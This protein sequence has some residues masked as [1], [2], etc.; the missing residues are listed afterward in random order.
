MYSGGQERGL[1]ERVVSP[2]RKKCL[3]L[4]YLEVVAE[5]PS[6][7]VF[8]CSRQLMLSVESCAKAPYFSA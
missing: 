3:M 6:L 2:C 7:A 1:A 5:L 8:T 4:F